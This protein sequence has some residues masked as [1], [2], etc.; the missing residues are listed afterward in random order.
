VFEQTFLPRYFL[1]SGKSGVFSAHDHAIA[2]EGFIGEPFV[3]RTLNAG[4]ATIS[5]HLH[6]NHFY[7]TAINAMVQDNAPDIDSMTIATVRP[8]AGQAFFSGGATVDWLVPLIRPPDIPGN[9]AT[10][11][12]D[13]IPEELGLVI[14]D[15]PQSPL[16]YPMHDHTEQSQ[17][18]AGGNYPQ[19]DVTDITF[20]GDLDKV[21]FPGSSCSGSGT[22]T[23]PGGSGGS[24]SGGSGTGK[25][26]GKKKGKK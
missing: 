14:G 1:I 12:R 11:L 7:V 25:K 20:L 16:K 18:A 2:I 19:G 8:Q 9:P 17:T 26:K 15:V 6:G 23:N 5:P 3:V 21:C 24:G 4:L 13:L 10:P 22:N